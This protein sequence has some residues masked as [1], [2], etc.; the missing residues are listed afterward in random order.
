VNKLKEYIIKLNSID[1]L[2]L[3]SMDW[4]ERDAVVENI[5]QQAFKQSDI[6]KEKGWSGY[7]EWVESLGKEWEELKKS[8]RR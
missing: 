5:V 1:I 7:G 6:F 2:C 3:R 8:K 4:E